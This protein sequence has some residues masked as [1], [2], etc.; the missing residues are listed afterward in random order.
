MGVVYRAYDDRLN[1]AVA[2]K[3]LPPEVVS[4][5]ERKRRFIQEARA[6]S[7]L[8]HPHIV[9]IHEIN[10]VDGIDFIV[11]ELVEGKTLHELIPEGGLL[12]A[13][14]VEYALQIAD[15][16]AAAHSKGIVHRDLKPANVMVTSA[17]SNGCHVSSLKILDFG[18]AKLAAADDTAPTG[19]HSAL[20][21]AGAILGTAAYMSPEQIDGGLIDS[22]SDI[23]SFGAVLYEMVSGRRAFPGGSALVTISAVYRT[24]PE[25]LG[26]GVPAS[27]KE[28]I[29]KCLR[30]KPGERFQS[31]GDVRLRLA[32]LK[33][34]LSPSVPRGRRNAR[35]FATT[36]VSVALVGVL[37]WIWIGSR[38]TSW[39]YSQIPE[40]R[41]L[42]S[43]YDYQSALLLSDKVQKYI[44]NDRDFKQL[45][46]EESWEG[47]VKSNP[48][49]ASVSIR[50]YGSAN[51]RW[52]EL[53]TTP[54]TNARIPRGALEWRFTKSGYQ[55][56]HFISNA[57]IPEQ[58]PMNVTMAEA[59]D[60][61]EGMV[62]IPG[63][64][65]F[66]LTLDSLI[67]ITANVRPF[68][69][70]KLEVTN[71]QFKEFVDK[72]GYSRRDLWKQPFIKDGH[73]I[74]WEKAMELFRDKTGQPGPKTWSLREYPQGQDDYPVTGV[75][76]YEAAA[77]AEFVG[78]ALPPVSYWNRAAMPQL[79]PHLIIPRS[80]FS[81]MG[82][83]KVGEGG[84]NPFGT[85]DMAG[86]VTEWCWNEEEPGLH[87][88]LGS[89]W[90]EPIYNFGAA[91]KADGFDRGPAKG[92]RLA[93]FIDNV[94][95][96]AEM[97]PLR[98]LPTDYNTIKP[99]SEGVYQGF[100]R[101]YTY[102]KTA[103][104][105]KTEKSV[106]DH[107]W[108]R[109]KVTFD[110][111]YDNERMIA[112]LFLP[113]NAKPPF[114]TV[115]FFP[116]LNVQTETNSENMVDIGIFSFLMRSGRAVVYPIYKGTYERGTGVGIPRGTMS[117]RDSRVQQF[118]DF[119]RTIDYLEARSDI[120]INKLG[121]YGISWGGGIGAHF[122]ALEK[123]I[124]V[125][126]LVHGGLRMDPALPEVEHF[127]FA[128]HVTI[129][130]LMLSGKYDFGFP[131]KTSQIPM[132]QR[133]GT[134]EADKCR[135]EFEIDHEFLPEEFP[136][137]TLAWLD[138]YFG[139]VDGGP[140]VPFDR[141]RCT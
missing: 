121:F 68:Y 62:Y 1:R 114:Q 27:L 127:N 75:S 26:S 128:S 16:L 4:D 105:A 10:A 81:R 103:L 76:W 88:S 3:V 74:S 25:P 92:F 111:A 101:F 112:Y 77:F 113:K 24:E 137:E 110:A 73:E 116:G 94:T 120:D 39:A 49:G 5:P 135:L 93:K 41:R 7:A 6:A 54:I 82:T 109:E 90:N 50:A 84:M 96:D 89:S 132:L 11:M 64:S 17:G 78:K 72:G 104:N 48:S 42:M 33:S 122:P 18:L 98:R 52:Q 13:E 97:R 67:H 108:K 80:N 134:P 29:T 20:T 136:K 95:D 102:D 66:G 23:F 56:A 44:P 43:T 106:D 79:I 40:V 126:V 69:L 86:N 32:K 87:Y 91:D 31:I 124:K 30:K 115:V 37:S 130:T 9:T 34:E 35:R 107:Y 65:P 14:G 36:F 133:L 138:H 15:A 100:L 2:L 61:P 19:T 99:V 55:E 63:A 22:R 53:G 118:K 38:N 51:D 58:A 125:N 8:N 60:V 70:D 123:R 71:R 117:H 45:L 12:I 47:P 83:Q 139:P 28:I 131:V 21:E 140:S 85:Y 59:K 46:T 129:P 141:K 57:L 119:A